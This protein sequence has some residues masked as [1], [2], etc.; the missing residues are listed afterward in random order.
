MAH[1]KVFTRWCN[2]HLEKRNLKIEDLHTD[3]RNGT[4]LINLVEIISG[5]TIK[6]NQKPVLRVQMIENVSILIKFLISEGVKLVNIGPEDIV[7]GN[8]RL[9]LALIWA[10]ILKYKLLVSE[11]DS[12]N[13]DLITWVQ[14][15]LKLDVKNFTTDWSDGKV[16]CGLIDSITQS[17]L[18]DQVTNDGSQ[19]CRLAI[20][21]AASKMDIP[22][23]LDPEDMV[24]NPDAQSN[25]TYIAYFREFENSKG[26]LKSEMTDIERKEQELI[27]KEELEKERLRQLEEYELEQKLLAEEEAKERE[28][29]QN[30]SYDVQSQK[31]DDEDDI[32]FEVL[33]QYIKD[34]EEERKFARVRQVHIPNCVAHGPGLKSPGM[35]CIKANFTI[36]ARNIDNT[37]TGEGGHPFLVSITG[38][39]TENTSLCVI[40][41][42]NGQYQVHYVPPTAGTYVIGVTL[43]G[44]SLKGSPF[45]VNVIKFK[46]APVA[47]WYYF[48]NKTWMPY[49][50][51]ISMVIEDVYQDLLTFE[52]GIGSTCV[53]HN[54]TQL[55]ID[56]KK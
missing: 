21:Y 17:H 42:E 41:K 40:D 37:L 13:D 55:N 27:Q 11:S 3:L 19:N 34:K 47:H 7:E 48:E 39:S 35:E 32:Q 22:R 9:T 16:L 52:N 45:T 36:E 43:E 6:Y 8:S 56:F 49:E 33:D 15:K 54:G 18:L 23:L 29:A 51:S 38:V 25:L 30:H 10:L 4:L 24:Q 50:D 1:N 20:E 2:T 14:K 12:A 26:K 46:T 5:K 31:R 28:R 44:V 53:T